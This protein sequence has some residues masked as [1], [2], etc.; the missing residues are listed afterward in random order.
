[1][2]N[3]EWAA[4]SARIA[5]VLEAGTYFMLTIGAGAHDYGAT[6]ALLQ[7]A[8]DVASRL[9]RFR[10]SHTAELPEPAIACLSRFLGSYKERCDGLSGIPATQVALT[11]LASFRAEF[12]Y[13]VSD[14]EALGR[15]LVTRAFMHLQRSIVA[16]ATFRE[17]WR[18]AF[19]EGETACEKLGACHLL[20][21][22]VWAFKANAAGERTDLVLGEPLSVTDEVRRAAATLVLTEWKVVGSSTELRDKIEQAHKQAQLYSSGAL[23]GFEL[24]SRRYLVMVSS[25]RL[26]MPEARREGSILYEHVNVP[27]SPRSPSRS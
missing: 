10:D 24:S 17:R 4:L 11:L 19:E 20:L 8:N 21:H 22:G 26:E 25:D 7:N 14:A 12:N 15:S 5:S 1:M 9:E 18:K 23:A 27:V 16:D 3:V 6:G 13:V 2:W